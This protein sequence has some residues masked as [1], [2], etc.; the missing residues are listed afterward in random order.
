MTTRQRASVPP[1]PRLLA[2]ALRVWDNLSGVLETAVWP[3]FDLVLRLWLAQAYFRS[4]VVKLGNWD[5]AVKLA[6]DEYPV[7]W[8]APEW[9]A[10]LGATIEV[11]GA[12]LL[13]F[14]LLTRFAA[15]PMAALALVIHTAYVA[16]G[17]N[18]FWAVLLGW[19]VV[20]G[21]GPISLDAAFARG[22]A[23]LPLP[24]VPSMARAAAHVT[25]YLG[26]V[27]RLFLRGWIAWVFLALGLALVGGIDNAVPSIVGD[28][29][30]P[31]FSPG[32][33]ALLAAT[34]A[35]VCPVLLLAG[36]ATRLAAILLLALTLIVQFTQPPHPEHAY[37]LLLLGLIA[38]R[39][40]GTLSLDAGLR[41]VLIRRYP[42][43]LLP[44]RWDDVGK[45]H[46]VIVGAGFGGVALVQALR[47]APC[48]ITLI[49]RRNYHLFQP[50]LYQVA[51]AGLSPADIAAPIRE[52]FRDQPN[53]RVILG[54]ATGIDTPGKAVL[55]G[56]RRVAYD[57]L[58]LA[59]GARHEYFGRDDWEKWAPGLKKIPDATAIRHWILSA[60]EQAEIAEDDDHRRACLTFVIVGGGP[61]GVELAG[62]IAE[63]AFHG[64]RGEFR[65][66]RPEATR[67][68]LVQAADRLLPPF[69]PSLSAATKAALEHLGVDVRLDARVTGIDADGVVLGDER[70]AARTVLWA[71]G[72]MASP[73][74]KWLGVAADRAGRVMVGDDLSVPDHPNIFVIGDTAASNAW[75]GRPVPG[76]APAA[77]QAGSYVARVIES[78]LLRH[79]APPPFVYRHA[80]NL[81]TIGRASAVADLGPLHLSGS[82]AWWFWGAVHVLFLANMRNMMSVTV[83]WIWAYLTFRRGSRLI[84][85]SAEDE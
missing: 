53:V 61:T 76:L 44:S 12:L 39:G 29:A 42:D 43:V 45:P 71:A 74:A 57:S 50:L 13:A 4:G 63:L 5:V 33:P 56:E 72:V 25:A 67:V 6:T 47:H 41:S 58:V 2:P 28:Y 78:R 26:P 34:L 7:A 79:P 32:L 15:L 8:L 66:A 73:A 3:V 10:V 27:Y 36:L 64:L 80:G 54:R 85:D 40:A 65:A 83:Q 14:G 9:A 68:V 51:T 16:T 46:V 59:T 21:A 11:G 22:V 20:M 77:K 52:L 17:V 37:W 75:S 23:R 38:L 24:L 31:H 60:F 84:A 82:L 1:A 49:D 30:R 70:I 62:A 55:L 35:L 19:Y 48:R 81:A 69:P 18:L